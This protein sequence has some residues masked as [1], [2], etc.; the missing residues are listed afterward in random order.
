MSQGFLSRI[1]NR[2]L[3]TALAGTTAL[4]NVVGT[5]IHR[6]NRLPGGVA[7][8]ACLFYMESSAYDTRMSNVPAE[9]IT[10][11]SYRF[12]VEIHDRSESDSRIAPA[13]E[14]QFAALAGTE[15]YTDDGY[16]IT[17]TAQGEVPL[18]TSWDGETQYQRLGTIY[19]VYVT[20]G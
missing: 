7:L 19:Q 9:H 14:G 16:Q 15:M 10:S 20:K 11:G 4:T 12:V 18:T 8:P 1:V 3:Y 5:R 6:G 13:A 17:L 2:E